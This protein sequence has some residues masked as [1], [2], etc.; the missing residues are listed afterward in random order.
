MANQHTPDS[1]RIILCVVWEDNAG[2][3]SHTHYMDE[4]VAT[5]YKVMNRKH[6][7]ELSARALR[8]EMLDTQE[9]CIHT[10]KAQRKLNKERR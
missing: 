5:S 4:S 3:F 10:V 2:A 7:R 6:A 9:P 1:D 8:V